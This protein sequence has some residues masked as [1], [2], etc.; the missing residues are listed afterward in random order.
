MSLARDPVLRVGERRRVP[1]WRAVATRAADGAVDVEYDDASYRLH[2]PSGVCDFVLYAVGAE[3]RLERLGMTERG[4]ALARFALDTGLD[5]VDLVNVAPAAV[6]ADLRAVLTAAHLSLNDLGLVDVR[7]PTEYAAAVTPCGVLLSAPNGRTTH[8]SDRQLADGRWSRVSKLG[9]RK[10]ALNGTPVGSTFTIID[11]EPPVWFRAL[12]AVGGRVGG[13]KDPVTVLAVLLGRFHIEVGYTPGVPFRVAAPIDVHARPV[14]ALATAGGVIEA[15]D[16]HTIAVHV[17]A[18]G[19]PTVF[20]P[21]KALVK[22]GVMRSAFPADVLPPDTIVVGTLV[23]AGGHNAVQR[24]G[25]YTF[26][27]RDAPLVAGAAIAGLNYA[28][29][30]ARIEAVVGDGFYELAPLLP[31]T[32]TDAPLL[33]IPNAAFNRAPLHVLQPTGQPIVA[34]YLGYKLKSYRYDREHDDASQR[35][36]LFGLRSD[37]AHADTRLHPWRGLVPAFYLYTNVDDSELEGIP[38]AAAGL[39]GFDGVEEWVSHVANARANTRRRFECH[40][41]RWLPFKKDATKER[42]APVTRYPEH[43]VLGAV[44]TAPVAAAG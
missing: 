16:G 33:V 25:P 37:E 30:R 8:L 15:V 28:E 4:A 11:R 40:A 39:S 29:R 38:V 21:T 36:H 22:V 17:A 10:Y 14:E 42:W 9:E 34:A 1:G 12:N 3:Y 24:G 32:T 5:A 7:A 13:A 44:T 35:L 43:V 6:R 31:T 23:R 27:V 20:W 2:P 26:Y 18:N 19:K 41:L